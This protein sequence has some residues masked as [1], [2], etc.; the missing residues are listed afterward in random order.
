M[1]DTLVERPENV[2]PELVVDFDFF[3]LGDKDEDIQLAFAALHDGPD[4]VWTPRN[5]GHWIATRAADFDVI[6]IDHEHF[7]HHNFNLPKNGIDA[8]SLPLGLDPPEHTPFRRLMMPAFMPK[9]VKALE[10]VA[11]ETARALVAK[12]APQGRCEFIEEFAK[13]LPINVFLGMVD[14]PLADRDM[15]LPWAEIAVRSPDIA[16]RADVHHKMQGYLGRYVDARMAEPGDDIISMIAKGEIDGRPIT[17]E[18]VLRMS[19]LLLFG[20]LDTVASQLGFI[21]HYLA[22]HPKQRA[23]L[24]GNPSLNQVACEELIRRF[25]LPNTAR[26]LTTDYDYKGIRFRKG[27]MIQMPK[28]LYG[29]DDRVNTDPR[30]VDFHRK[31]STI[32]HAAFGAGPHTCPGAVLARREIMVFFDEWLPAIPD[33]E[34][35]PDDEVVMAS[36]P[37][38][39]VL[40]LPL[41]WKV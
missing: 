16:Q 35:D 8:T 4:I 1:I 19:T 28:C 32:K 41:R 6:Q 26:V 18:E 2:P 17:R 20:G 9:A 13:I 12:I 10:G 29:L 27:D 7:S 22:R 34:L 37:V 31:P 14:L 25:G 30:T 38:N 5:G 3:A 40:R 11:R 24:V 23:E 39:G 33:F 36:G 15:L 21:A